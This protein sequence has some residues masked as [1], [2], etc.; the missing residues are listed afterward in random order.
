MPTYLTAR[1]HLNRC[2]SLAKLL[3]N[4]LLPKDQLRKITKYK[5]S[6]LVGLGFLIQQHRLAESVLKLGKDHS[7]EAQILIRSMIEIY[8]N[9]KWILLCAKEYRANRFMKFQDLERLVI[10]NNLS[11][12]MDPHEYA[13]QSKKLKG[14]C[15]KISHLFRKRNKKGRLV[16]SKSWASVTSF[17]SRLRQVLKSEIDKPDD[18]LYGLY[19]SLSSVVHGG[20][21]S[22]DDVMK[23]WLKLRT[24]SEPE[25]QIIGGFIILL[26]SIRTLAEDTSM[27]KIIE[28]ELSKLE[29]IAYR[30]TM[31]KPSPS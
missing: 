15:A 24:D 23:D 2:I 3:E 16:W 31:N 12:L 27:I 29:K 7:Y 6:T 20:P 1:S 18:F 11:S 13:V 4:Q 14:R 10:S 9:H 26:D 30:K 8:F 28:T 22:H 17:E 19:R 5:K 25:K 21:M